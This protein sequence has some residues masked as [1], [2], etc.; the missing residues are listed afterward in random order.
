MY[1]F[2]IWLWPVSYP[3]YV[4]NIGTEIIINNN[5]LLI[6]STVQ[7]ILANLCILTMYY[8]YIDSN[9]ICLI[10]TYHSLTYKQSYDFY[11]EG[12]TY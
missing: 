6:I 8:T 5:E 2:N 7:S 4:I 9:T 12:F 11:Q 1:I 10:A 3:P